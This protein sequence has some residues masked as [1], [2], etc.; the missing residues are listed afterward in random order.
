MTSVAKEVKTVL[1]ERYRDYNAASNDSIG[2][3]IDDDVWETVGFFDG[4]EKPF[5][6]F[7]TINLNTTW[8][9][10]WCFL[11]NDIDVWASEI[12]CEGH[13]TY[14][15]Y[16]PGGRITAQKMKAL[17]KGESFIVDNVFVLCLH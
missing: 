11:N 6:F 5:R 7:T 10:C 13:S 4:A 17:K 8:Q 16:V 1:N 3:L 14:N 9:A 15:K 12:S 2:F